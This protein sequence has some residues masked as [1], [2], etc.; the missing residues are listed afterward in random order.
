MDNNLEAFNTRRHSKL[1]A[2]VNDNKNKNN[3]KF[4]I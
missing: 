3:Y 2:I 1:Q 4:L